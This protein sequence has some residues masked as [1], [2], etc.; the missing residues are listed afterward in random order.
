MCIDASRP[1]L[2]WRLST[3]AVRATCE[4]LRARHPAALPG[5]LGLLPSR[6]LAAA[7]A[8]P[9]APAGFT[10]PT[11]SV[12]WRC[13]GSPGMHDASPADHLDRDSR[14]F[15]LFRQHL[16]PSQCV[17]KRLWYVICVR[18]EAR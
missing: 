9:F 5:R 12:I 2:P 1:R 8:D 16:S 3:L 6:A 14:F 7:I 15:D 4:H 13:R 17:N 18:R 11:A 10:P